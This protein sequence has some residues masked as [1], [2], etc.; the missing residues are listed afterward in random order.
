MPHE[1]R[2]GVSV[3]P[4]HSKHWSDPGSADTSPERSRL[5]DEPMDLRPVVRHSETPTSRVGPFPSLRYQLFD[6]YRTEA[7]QTSRFSAMTR[8]RSSADKPVFG[9]GRSRPNFDQQIGLEGRSMRQ[10]LFGF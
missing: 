3:N 9:A 8:A 5:M 7:T 6:R 10:D 2:A 1:V 4:G